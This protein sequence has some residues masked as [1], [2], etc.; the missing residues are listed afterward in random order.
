MINSEE[1]IVMIEKQKA[2]EISSRESAE[3]ISGV[4]GL[5]SGP[6]HLPDDVLEKLY[7]SYSLKQKR[8]GLVCFIA[9]SVVFDLWAI[10]VPQGQSVETY[11]ELNPV[12]H[13]FSM[14]VNGIN[15]SI[16]DYSFF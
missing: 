12:L 13:E 3:R 10:L 2:S 7:R 1:E 14:K 16:R 4:V 9:A 5:T 11:G 8:S 15:T 6:T